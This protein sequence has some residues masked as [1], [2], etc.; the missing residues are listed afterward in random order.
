[1]NVDQCTARIRSYVID[2]CGNSQRGSLELGQRLKFVFMNETYRL[3]VSEIEGKSE[4]LLTIDI[5]IAPTKS[6]SNELDWVRRYH[7]DKRTRLSNS[8]KR[9]EHNPEFN[10]LYFSFSTS[11]DTMYKSQLRRILNSMR[12]I[13]HDFRHTFNDRYS[14]LVAP[15]ST[16]EVDDGESNL[17]KRIARYNNTNE[18]IEHDHLSSAH[19]VVH[20][21]RNL[22]TEEI[23]AELD[24]LVGLP[25]VKN[26]IRQIVA[27]QRVDVRRR[28]LL[29]RGEQLSPHLV[30]VGNPGTGKTTVARLL[31]ELYKSI[32]L[33]KSGHVVET[34]RSGLVGAFVGSSAVKTRRICKLA[35]DGVLFIDE[36]YTLNSEDS[37]SDYGPE[38]VA[39]LLTFME[40]NRGRVA[41]VIAG[42]PVEMNKL[43][44]SNPGLR[45]RFDNTVIFDDY[46][47]KELEEIFLEMIANNDYELSP[48][49]FVAVSNYIKALPMP[50]PHSFA[51]GREMRKLLN[52]IVK[53]QAEYVLRTFDLATATEE[54][55]RFIPAESVPPALV[56][57]SSEHEDNGRGLF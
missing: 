10:D 30:F 43:L 52:E 36:A 55:L 2:L 20:Q 56:W 26:E 27:A 18:G 19:D 14:G 54:Q 48:E 53:N 25:D 22:S 37:D 17:A 3:R 38:A 51:N 15:R 13:T 1:M 12:Q 39:T 45:S 7:L 21:V 41:L 28:E 50:R 31:G 33:L 5:F 23:L 29:M 57:K 24:Q 47:D 34:E 8:L 4:V 9:N 49:A 35:L 42:Y 40:N 6:A 46:D 44:R 16:S 11:A 32:G